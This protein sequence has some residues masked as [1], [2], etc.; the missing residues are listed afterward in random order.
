MTQ[1][2]LARTLKMPKNR[3]SQ[4]VNGERGI[5]ADTA[6][7]LAHWMGTTPDSWLNLQ[8][9]YELRL[10]EQEHGEMIRKDVVPL[11]RRVA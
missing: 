9:M 3:I 6:L 8:K 11:A 4:I 1:A 10:A 2:A 7:R 5:T